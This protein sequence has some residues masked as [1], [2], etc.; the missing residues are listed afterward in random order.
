MVAPFTA[1]YDRYDWAG[2]KEKQGLSS[3]DPLLEDVCVLHDNIRS[4]CM[5]CMFIR[6]V[7]F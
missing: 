6:P 7:D 1:K 4:R 3:P 2:Q 5:K